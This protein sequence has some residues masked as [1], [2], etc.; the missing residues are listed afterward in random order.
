MALNFKE[1]AKN[2]MSMSELHNGRQKLETETV[3]G[4]ALTIEDFDIAQLDD[5]STFAVFTFTETPKMY[6]NGGYVLTKMVHGW[7]EE[8]GGDIAKAREEYASLKP[9]DRVKIQLTL[10]KTKDKARSLVNVEVL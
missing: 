4:K 10:T 2:N 9:A 7:V 1:I 3:C 5:G 8:C 6:Y